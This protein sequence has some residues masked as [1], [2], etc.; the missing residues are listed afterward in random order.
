LLCWTLTCC[1]F[2]KFTTVCSK[3]KFYLL[4]AWFQTKKRKK[5]Y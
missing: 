2:C 1:T 3:S 4:L 5:K